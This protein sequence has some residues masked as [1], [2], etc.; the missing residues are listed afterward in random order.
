MELKE[1]KKY[2]IERNKKVLL[3][4]SNTGIVYSAINEKYNSNDNFI[5]DLV[6]ELAKKNRIEPYEFDRILQ[7]EYLQL[8]I[9]V[10]SV[11]PDSFISKLHN[12]CAPIYSLEIM[13]W[14]YSIGGKFNERSLYQ[15]VNVWNGKDVIERVNFLLNISPELFDVE[16]ILSM[17]LN[18]DNFESI[19]SYIPS[20]SDAQKILDSMFIS[21]LEII[22]YL[23]KTWEIKTID[24]D[25]LIYNV[26][27]SGYQNYLK[28]CEYYSIDP[29]E[30]MSNVFNN[31]GDDE[32]FDEFFN[33]VKEIKGEE[34]LKIKLQNLKDKIFSDGYRRNLRTIN[35]LY[36]EKKLAESSAWIEYY[37]FCE[38]EGRCSFEKHKKSVME[39]LDF[40]KQF[41]PEYDVSF[42]NE[43]ELDDWVN[44]NW[45]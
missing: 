5:D 36:K 34:Y 45:S 21:N 29:D 44:Y 11:L 42:K 15:V 16:V 35:S 22:K 4:S 33:E 3:E 26:A 9:E 30:I 23:E 31:F 28:A 20:K 12:H 7:C 25:I 27:C 37:I 32:T 18:D 2:I 6:I 41:V 10:F 1:I 14:W 13:K 17:D 43:E 24:P 8:A 19:L 39:I 38:W 40:Y